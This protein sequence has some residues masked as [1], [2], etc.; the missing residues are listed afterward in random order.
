MKYEEPKMQIV[1]ETEDVIRTS[2]KLDPDYSG[3]DF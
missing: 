3:E 2:L 1:L